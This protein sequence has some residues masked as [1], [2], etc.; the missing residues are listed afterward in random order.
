MAIISTLT[1]LWDREIDCVSKFTDC[2][3]KSMDCVHTW[4]P[5]KFQQGGKIFPFREGDYK[6]WRREGDYFWNLGYGWGGGKKKIFL[7]LL[8][9]KG[10]FLSKI[11]NVEKYCYF[12]SGFVEQGGVS[13]KNFHFFS[14]GGVKFCLRE[15]DCV[16]RVSLWASP[17]VPLPLPMCGDH[18]L[19]LL[20]PLPLRVFLPVKQQ[21]TSPVG[22]K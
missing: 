19:S 1:V 15:G 12:L 10:K 16:L 13:H 21:L 14:I 11:E 4:A 6:K 17:P 8:S 3:F 2:V 22:R 20:L 5:T 9:L 18:P 7:L